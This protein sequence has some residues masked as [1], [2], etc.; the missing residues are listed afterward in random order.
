[1]RR[2][3]LR[4]W[5][6][7]CGTES[8]APDSRPP[9]MWAHWR[10]APQLCRRRSERA[11]WVELVREE[12]AVPGAACRG[13]GVEAPWPP[14]E[15]R[16]FLPPRTGV[17]GCPAAGRPVCPECRGRPVV[18]VPEAR[19]PRPLAWEDRGVPPERAE[20]DCPAPDRGPPLEP[21]CRWG[22]DWEP[23]EERPAEEPA[24][25]RAEP[26]RPALS[27][28]LRP[29]P[30]A[31]V[32]T[33]P[34]SRSQARE[35]LAPA[36]RQSVRPSSLSARGGPGNPVPN[37]FRGPVSHTALCEPL[38]CVSG[39]LPGRIARRWTVREAGRWHRRRRWR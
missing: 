7:P 20:E 25:R 22:R 32:T 27:P 1:M 26:R 30:L 28:W 31:M 29:R 8:G 13:R 19:P 11:A 38:G 6:G 24:P 39:R 5:S 35:R 14:W 9:P 33:L 34:A 4:G 18:F 3:P 23:E 37:G 17:P 12:R 2:R 15:D 36:M 21:P 16:R 10:P